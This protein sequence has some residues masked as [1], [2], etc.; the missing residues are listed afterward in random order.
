MA[1]K[2]RILNVVASPFPSNQGTAGATRELVTAL[3]NKGHEIHIVTYYQGQNIDLGGIKIHR[4][5]RLG[6]P[7]NF[8]V[9]FNL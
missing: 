8:F 3:A 4:I 1:K 9:G 2:L 7:N 6:D 5:P